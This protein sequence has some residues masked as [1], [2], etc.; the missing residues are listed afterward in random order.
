MINVD[1][2]LN[3]DV[4]DCTLKKTPRYLLPADDA[5]NQLRAHLQR[6]DT[7]PEGLIKSLLTEIERP[8][9]TPGEIQKQR[10]MLAEHLMNMKAGWDADPPFL[11]REHTEMSLFSL[12]TRSDQH[13][14]RLGHSCASSRHKNNPKTISFHF[15]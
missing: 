1:L 11:Q 13:V 8:Q 9:T 5:F 7:C 10:A 14:T 3:H 2:P 15:L 6:G 4:I 12:L